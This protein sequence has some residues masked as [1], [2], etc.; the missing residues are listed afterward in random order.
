MACLL[1]VGACHNGGAG[2][3]QMDAAVETAPDA[4]PEVGAPDVYCAP[5]AA[6]GGQCPKNFCGQPKTVASLQAGELSQLGSDE[7]CTPGYSC[8]PDVPAADGKSLVLRCV[9]PQDGA[10]TFGA[11]CTKGA[12]ARCKN[13]ALCIEAPG[14]AGAFCS[15]LCRSDRDCPAEAYCLE[16]KSD[17]VGASYV[18]LGYCTP[19]AKVAAT[20]CTREAQCA[21]DQGCVSYGV[22]TSLLTCQ[23][24]GGAKALGEACT[25][26][27]QCRS[28]EC[29]DREFHQWGATHRAYCSGQCAK[30]SDCAADQRCTRIVLGNNGTPA[31]PFDDVVAGYC[32]SLFAVVAPGCTAN[33]DCVNVQAGDT[34]DVPH[35]ICYTTGAL[36][37]APCTADTGCGLGAVCLKGVSFPNGYCQSLGCA[38]GQTTGV[39]A[40]PGGAEVTCARR[41]A[42]DEPLYG[43]YEGCAQSGDCSRFAERYVCA[44]PTKGAAASICLYDSGS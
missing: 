1:L 34:C 36:P 33:G 19:K 37:G 26:N 20:P 14:V 24:V 27:A 28:G 13:D 6:G 18:N 32:Q 23:K 22:R 39:D 44:P 10:V 41:G 15:Q 31:D 5:D 43:C 21:A 12:G 30:N 38:P 7:A 11:A 17:A 25:A 3:R 29:F 8:V 16:R 35:G 2:T 42:A 9:A 40:C 4:T